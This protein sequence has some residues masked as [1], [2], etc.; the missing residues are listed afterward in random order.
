MK[1]R[2]AR[3]K[4]LHGRH[5]ATSRYAAKGGPYI[6]G[7]S[8]AGVAAT[9]SRPTPALPPARAENQDIVFATR[10]FHG[11]E[12][13][14]KNL[15]LGFEVAA[16]TPED[17]LKR[18]FLAVAVQGALVRI[19]QHVGTF[20]DASGWEGSSKVIAQSPAVSLREAVNAIRQWSYYVSPRQDGKDTQAVTPRARTL[21]WTSDVTDAELDALTP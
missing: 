11:W 18:C 9:L 15:R 20:N 1:R 5:P 6:Y 10:A 2:T 16:A 12:K 7:D 13:P 21:Y 8:G 19:E 14:S 3:Q 17:S 4:G